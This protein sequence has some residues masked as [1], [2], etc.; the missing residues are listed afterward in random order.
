MSIYLFFTGPLS[1]G[2]CCRIISEKRLFAQLNHGLT[3]TKERDK[4]ISFC[5]WVSLLS[6]CLC[7]VSVSRIISCALYVCISVQ[8]SVFYLSA[9]LS[10]CVSL[11]LSVSASGSVSRTMFLRP[12]VP[13][14]SFQAFQTYLVNEDGEFG[15][16]PSCMKSSPSATLRC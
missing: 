4:K 16:N 8:S 13:S 12:H 3:N 2:R 5:L 9:F 10:L 1:C 11:S 6:L 14:L 15:W 7:R